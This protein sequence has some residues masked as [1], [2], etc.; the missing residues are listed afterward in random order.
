MDKL[1]P[2]ARSAEDCALVLEAIYGPDGKDASVYP[3]PISLESESRLA[4]AAHRLF[5]EPP[6]TSPSR[7][8]CTRPQPP[9]PPKKRRNA[10][11]KTRSR[12]RPARAADYDRRYDLAALD[13][14]RAMGVNLIPVELPKLPYGAMTPLLTAEAAA[15]FDDLT[16]SGR[17]KLLTEQGP[18]D[19][20]N[21]FRVAPLLPGGRIHP[22]Q[23]R[24]HAGR[25]SRFRRSSS[26]W[27]SSSRRPPACSLWPPI[28]PAIRPSSCPTACAATMLPDRP[29]STTATSDNIGGPGTP[30]SLTFLAGHYQDAKLAAFGRAYQDATGFHKL[31]PKL[32]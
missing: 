14:L 31:H 24:A 18:E 23:P 4:Q 13:K 12:K 26:R 16:I 10:K 1:G 32:D 6:S 8:N 28:S 27:T 3:P 2:I 21:D 25:A 7:S 19:W 29:R 22:G 20:P 5:E 15:A 11:R 17:D 30:V 9:K